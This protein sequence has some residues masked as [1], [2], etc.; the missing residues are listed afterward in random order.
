MVEDDDIINKT[1][2]EKYKVIKKLGQGSFGQVYSG[3]NIKNEETIA[4]KFVN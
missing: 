1:F 4:L 2:F 3:T